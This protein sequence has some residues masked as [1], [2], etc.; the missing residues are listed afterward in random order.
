[1]W[2]SRTEVQ[3]SKKM[4]YENTGS[5]SKNSRKEQDKHPDLRGPATVCCPNC[6]SSNEYW[7]SGWF[8]VGRDSAKFIS[9]AFRPK[10]EQPHHGNDSGRQLAEKKFMRAADD[11]DF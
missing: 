5:L 11:I 3:T 6:N 7:L 4:A 8:K 1:M 10:E 9:L 2:K